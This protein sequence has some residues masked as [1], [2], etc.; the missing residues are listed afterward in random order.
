MVEIKITSEILEFA[1][2][3]EIELKRRLVLLPNTF[4]HALSHVVCQKYFGDLEY[5]GKGTE[6]K[7]RSKC[8]VSVLVHERMNEPKIHFNIGFP[9]SEINKSSDYCVFVC[10][11][12]D[13]G[14]TP[15]RAFVMGVYPTDLFLTESKFCSAGSEHT[16]GH[17]TWSVDSHEIQL[18][19]LWNIKRLGESRIP[20]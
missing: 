15:T 10:L 4:A 20:A 6:L 11:V 19:K 16:I 17:G 18:R 5:F 14:K 1:R 12:G 9:E 8:R 7:Y 2:Q 3:R 13:R